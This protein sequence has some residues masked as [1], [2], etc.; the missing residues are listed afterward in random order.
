M[1][2]IEKYI[3]VI[4]INIILDIGYYKYKQV[5]LIMIRITYGFTKPNSFNKTGRKQ[6]PDKKSL[7]T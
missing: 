1:N 5:P 7:D 6:T 4:T 3:K 2:V